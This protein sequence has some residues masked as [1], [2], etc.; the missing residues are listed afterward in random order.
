MLF[1][2]SI[3]PATTDHEDGSMAHLVAR[4][5]RII[6]ESGLP[7]ETGPMF[8]TVEGDWD[9]VM[10]VIKA[11]CDAI[12]EVS[13]RASLVLKADLRPGYEGQIEAKVER[14]EAE[15]ADPEEK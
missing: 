15:L 8:T 12:L 10:P 3:A 11:A 4:A 13:P 1:S 14:L 7:Q 2:F 9:E 6:R 5:V